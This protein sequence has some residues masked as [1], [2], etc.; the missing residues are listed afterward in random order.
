MQPILNLLDDNSFVEIGAL[1]KNSTV[2]TGYGT[3]NNRLVFVFCQNG[4]VDLL[5]AKKIENIYSNA[6]KTGSPVIGILNSNGMN[7]KGGLEILDAYGTILKTQADASGVILQICY[8]TGECIGTSAFMAGVSDFVFMTDKSG[9]LCLESPNVYTD[10][11]SFDSNSVL[12]GAYHSEKTGLA[13]FSYKTDEQ[14]INGIRELVGYLP[15]NYLETSEC[16]FTEDDLNRTDE[17]LNNPNIDM[18]SIINSLAD[19]KKFLNVN[20]NYC[21]NLIT[22]FSSFGGYTAA[23]VANNGA[24]NALALQK[25][26][27]FVNF[28]DAFNIPIVNL[29]DATCYEN[30][31]QGDSLSIR[32]GAKLI[33]AYANATVPKINVIVKGAVGSSYLIMN[34]KHIGADV[35]IAWK[36]SFVSVME[37]EAASKLFNISIDKTPLDAASYGY[38][39][40]IIEPS[41]T[42]KRLIMHLEMLSSK[43]CSNHAKKHCSI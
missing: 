9:K 10:A 40:D 17:A 7:I 29:T 23:V 12:N 35:V 42:R 24:L 14:C 4:S 26:S 11:K 25:A 8:V 27:D 31:L 3:I 21:K 36:N 20:G 28:C 6:L 30:N 15:S 37:K 22:G 5:H 41:I 39:D 34:S 18:Q 38:V 19:D 13:H 43:R 1:T 32:N 33:R 16:P 2:I